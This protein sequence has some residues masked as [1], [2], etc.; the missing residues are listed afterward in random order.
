MLKGLTPPANF[1]FALQ[2]MWLDVVL[3]CEYMP[4]LLLP[5]ITCIQL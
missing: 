2:G 1:Y 5:S 4:H 3:D